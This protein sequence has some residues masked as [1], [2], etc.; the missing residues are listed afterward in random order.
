MNMKQLLPL[1][2][3]ET[4]QYMIKQSRARKCFRGRIFYEWV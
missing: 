2:K 4:K 1:G 3:V